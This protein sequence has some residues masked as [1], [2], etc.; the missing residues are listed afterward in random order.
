M[1]HR[2]EPVGSESEFGPPSLSGPC[3]LSSEFSHFRVENPGKA[4]LEPY[5]RL[6][7]GESGLFYP[8][9]ESLSLR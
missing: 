5:F 6:R 9:I 8:R 1:T 4:G 7:S 3:Y 2:C